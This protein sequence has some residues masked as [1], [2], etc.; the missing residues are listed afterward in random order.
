MLTPHETR[1]AAEAFIALR[2]S[3][4]ADAKAINAAF[5]RR[6][7]AVHPDLLEGD[8]AEA[9]KVNTSRDYLVKLGEQGKLPAAVQAIAELE[10]ALQAM[11][12]EVRL[13]P[14]IPTGARDRAVPNFRKQVVLEYAGGGEY[15]LFLYGTFHRGNLTPGGA[16]RTL[17]RLLGPRFQ[18]SLADVYVWI[19][20]PDVTVQQFSLLDLEDALRDAIPADAKP[21]TT[22]GAHAAPVRAPESGFASDPEPPRQEETPP[23]DLLQRLQ[24][25]DWSGMYLGFVVVVERGQVRVFRLK[26]A[27]GKVDASFFGAYESSA[28][29]LRDLGRKGLSPDLVPVWLLADVL[30]S[31]PTRLGAA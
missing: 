1:L 7:T 9:T 29:A 28:A 5:K 25:V 26:R 14:N 4:T 27:R 22:R 17:R 20:V 13:S 23:A 21:R 19:L 12:E 24:G 11:S 31:E 8:V 30:G 6:I 18:G 10:A 16:M 2:L 3:P 15:N